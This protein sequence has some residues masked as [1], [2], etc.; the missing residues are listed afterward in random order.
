MPFTK[1]RHTTRDWNKARIPLLATGWF[2]GG[3]FQQGWFSSEPRKFEGVRHTT[4]N[5]T[6]VKH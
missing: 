3:W 2:K 5:W 4:R 1:V 6:K